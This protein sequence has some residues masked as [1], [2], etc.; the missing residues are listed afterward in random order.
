M[1][2]RVCYREQQHQGVGIVASNGGRDVEREGGCD[3]IVSS[4]NVAYLVT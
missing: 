4:I 1:N 3:V 2:R